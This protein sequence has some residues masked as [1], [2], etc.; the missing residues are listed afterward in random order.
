MLP[1]WNPLPDIKNTFSKT[2]DTIS[3]RDRRIL[4]RMTPV[5]NMM[6][7]TL[8]KLFKMLMMVGAQSALR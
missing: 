1:R 3:G 6:I 7:L 2:L 5:V 4:N 8:S